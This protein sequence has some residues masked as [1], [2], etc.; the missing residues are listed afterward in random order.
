MA[1]VL[2]DQAVFRAVVLVEGRLGDARGADQPVDADRAD[3]V[4]VEELVRGLQDAELRRGGGQ[5]RAG[6]GDLD[7]HWG[8]LSVWVHL[9]RSR[10]R[11]YRAISVLRRDRRG[12]GRGCT[13]LQNS[14]GRNPECGVPSGEVRRAR[15][16]RPSKCDDSTCGQTDLSVC[17]HLLSPVGVERSTGPGDD[18]GFIPMNGAVQLPLD[19]AELTITA[20]GGSL[21][22]RSVLPSGVRIL[23]EQVP[24]IAERDRR[25]LGRR[26]L[27][28]RAAGH[29][30]L[31][32]LPRAPAL[33]GH[34]DRAPRSTSRSRST[35]SAASTTR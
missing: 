6:A 19:L 15:V 26:R 34:E 17:P 1:D 18:V 11:G 24:G 13:V 12:S 8:R 35:R 25:I 30:R 5:G 20:S 28:R 33:Q 7:R 4:V 3:A 32:P 27:P 16:R 9:R 22:R 31:D 2:G 23:S 29:L 14:G 21:V 10:V